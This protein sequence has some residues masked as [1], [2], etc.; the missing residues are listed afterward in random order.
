MSYKPYPCQFGKFKFSY[1]EPRDGSRVDDKEFSQLFYSNVKYAAWKELEM[2]DT[3]ARHGFIT[4]HRDVS[5]GALRGYSPGFIFTPTSSSLVDLYLDL[6]NHPYSKV[7]LE[8]GSHKYRRDHHYLGCF[9]DPESPFRIFSRVPLPNCPESECSKCVSDKTTV[10]QDMSV[11]K[12][13]IKFDIDNKENIPNNI[14]ALGDNIG[15]ADN[16]N[17]SVFP[18]PTFADVTKS[19]R[20]NYRKHR[21]NLP[22]PYPDFNKN[23][24]GSPRP[25]K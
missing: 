19:G 25:C 5:L 14:E 22:T 4:L 9:R 11:S 17:N 18:V 15:P 24:T 10:D 1:F 13:D 2:P 16:I 3:I 21:Y 23:Y 6:D 8:Y 7:I 20:R 12:P